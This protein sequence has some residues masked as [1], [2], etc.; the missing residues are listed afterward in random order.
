MLFENRD[1]KHVSFSMNLFFSIYNPIFQLFWLKKKQKQNKHI[2]K[3]LQILSEYFFFLFLQNQIC[4]QVLI[5]SFRVCL[6]IYILSIYILDLFLNFDSY[7]LGDP[8]TF[9][10]C[11]FQFICP[12][13]LNDNSDM[14]VSSMIICIFTF[15]IFSETGNPLSASFN[16]INCI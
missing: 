5:F 2:N 15:F 11:S 6:N 4:Y 13:T 14:H 1:I 16:L 10:F 12:L 7:L 3:K 8:L 9:G